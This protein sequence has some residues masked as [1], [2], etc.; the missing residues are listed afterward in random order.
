MF[1]PEKMAHIVAD[2]NKLVLVVEQD[3]HLVGFSQVAL[4]RDSEYCELPQ[5]AELERLYIQE[6]FCRAG[7]GRRLLTE[8]ESQ[9]GATGINA[10]WLTTWVNNLRARHF[11]PKMAYA[12]VGMTYFE[13]EGERHENRIFLKLLA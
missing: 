12:D 8:T 11:Y 7:L 10:L 5:Q 9:L 2:P 13:M 3:D 4:H 1:T 6:P